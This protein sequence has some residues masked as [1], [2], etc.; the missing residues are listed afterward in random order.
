MRSA[1]VNLPDPRIENPKL[2]R[3]Q[4]TAWFRRE[5]RD[6][7]WRRTA[8]PY[9][10]LVSEFMLQQ[11]QVTTVVPYYERWLARF[12]TFAAL[13]AAS[14]AD[15]LSLWQ[16]L[17]YYSRAR[18]LHRAAGEVV[19]RFAGILPHDPALLATLPGVGRY[20]AGAIAAFAFD[21]PVPTIDGNIARVLARLIDLRVPID[22]EPGKT[23]LW[24]AAA[25]LQPKRAGR[26]F[27]SALMELGALVCTARAPRCTICPVRGHCATTE[28]ESLP[29][30]KT[31]PAIVALDESSAWI[32]HSDRM[33]LEQQIGPR[34]RGMWK[35]PPV[36]CPT[37]L[38][39]PPLLTL[40][41]PFTNHRVTLRA[42]SQAPPRQLAANQRW[43]ST[44]DFATLAI[45]APHR[46]AITQL[47]LHAKV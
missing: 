39:A 3:A 22:A 15:V 29:V 26:I 7:P 20:T 13:A 31:R 11:T 23:I 46:R 2:F 47:L 14:E 36:A 28:P 35:L 44:A 18:N 16:G 1:P 6:L 45:T 30:K 27:N 10:I 43:I 12:P 24:S 33:L 21:L 41:Y 17:G 5:G 38:S 34:W 32:F 4:I 40:T 25:A 37:P 8:D 19:E 9:A 42:Y